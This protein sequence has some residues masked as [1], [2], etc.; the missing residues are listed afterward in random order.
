MSENETTKFNKKIIDEFRAN[1]GIVGAPFAEIPLLLLGTIGAKSGKSRLNPLAYNKEG[2]D[3]I[4]VASMAGANQ[5]PPWFYN[6]KAN[7]IVN[8]EIDEDNFQAVA[9]ITEE[10]NRTDFYNR[11]EEKMPMFADYKKKTN[12][13]IPVILLE[14]IL[15]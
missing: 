1:K 3:I 15:N 2:K 6:L 9:K 7:P 14:R 5:N 4:V 10:P 13:I 11:I 8:V 12:R